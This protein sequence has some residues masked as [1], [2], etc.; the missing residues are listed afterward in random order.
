M[1]DSIDNDVDAQ[2]RPV[3]RVVENGRQ[4]EFFGAE[5]QI[6]LENHESAKVAAVKKHFGLRMTKLI[7]P[8]GG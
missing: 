1:A 3:K 7:P 4:I 5:D 8:G 2:T 6:R